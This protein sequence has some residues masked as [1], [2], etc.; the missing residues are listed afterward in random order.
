MLKLTWIYYDLLDLYADIGNIRVI[1]DILISN[2]IE[3]TVDK[4]TVNEEYDLRQSDIIFI[5]G[6]AD[7]EQSIVYKDLLKRKSMRILYW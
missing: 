2:N 7:F 4:V 3:Y 5:G 6:G 1:E